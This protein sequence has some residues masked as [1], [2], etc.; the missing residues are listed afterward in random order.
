[1][2]EKSSGFSFTL[3]SSVEADPQNEMIS[4]ESP[5]GEALFGAKKGDKVTVDAPAGKIVYEIKALS[6]GVK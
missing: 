6:K 2:V 1:M 3:V 4:V 5:L